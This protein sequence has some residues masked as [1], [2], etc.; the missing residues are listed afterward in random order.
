M[1]IFLLDL[2][3]VAV[4]NATVFSLQIFCPP[5]FLGGSLTL[6]SL[7]LGPP[8]IDCSV[9]HLS[10]CPIRHLPKPLVNCSGQGN[11]VQG[12]SPH[13]CSQEVWWVA[14]NAGAATIPSIMPRLTPSPKL[15]LDTGTLFKFLCPTDIFLFYLREMLHSQH[16]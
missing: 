15:F 2:I 7:L 4:L 13:K 16:F 5:P 11:T 14:L 3:T 1:N 6:Y 10:A 8:F 9:H 12:F